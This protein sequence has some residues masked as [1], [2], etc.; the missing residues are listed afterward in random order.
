M[1][2]VCNRKHAISLLFSNDSD[3][4]EFFFTEDRESMAWD[5]PYEA[6]FVSGMMSRERA[7][8]IR[9]ALDIW[10]STEFSRLPEIC[11]ILGKERFEAFT[12]AM[13]LLWGMRGCHCLG[14]TQRLYPSHRR[15]TDILR[16]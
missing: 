4:L 5:S 1:S 16:V 12:M 14:C 10:N 2:N 6:A 7:I 13:E 8:L 11:Q 3:L 9:V 15:A